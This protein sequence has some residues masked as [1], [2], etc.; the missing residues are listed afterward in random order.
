MLYRSYPLTGARSATWDP[1]E[2]LEIGPTRSKD[3]LFRI[4]VFDCD[5]KGGKHLV[6][7]ETEVNASQLTQ[8]PSIPILRNGKIKGYLKFDRFELHWP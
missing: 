3:L 8:K 2:A 6:I 4:T 5:I 7:G 1:V